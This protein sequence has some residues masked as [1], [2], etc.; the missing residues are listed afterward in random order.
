MSKRVHCKNEVKM[1]LQL[2]LEMMLFASITESDGFLL[3]NT[4]FC[5]QLVLGALA[6][7]VV[8]RC[9]F[10]RSDS[11]LMCLHNKKVLL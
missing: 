10:E 7:S 3:L 5:E 11:R 8:T 1:D 9:Q 4:D 2:T 6:P